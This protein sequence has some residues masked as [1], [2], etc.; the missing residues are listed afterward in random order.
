MGALPTV[1]DPKQNLKSPPRASLAHEEMGDRMAA[2]LHPARLWETSPTTLITSALLL[3]G[4]RVDRQIALNVFK[5]V[6]MPEES[7]T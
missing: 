3:T 7:D 6:S 1:G 4:L 2:R 5:G